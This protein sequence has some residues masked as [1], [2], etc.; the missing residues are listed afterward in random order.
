MLQAISI[1]HEEINNAHFKAPEESA[2]VQDD[3][4]SPEEALPEEMV[5]DQ[6][7]PAV[8]PVKP[9]EPSMNQTE[10]VN[11]EEKPARISSV[12]IEAI[13]KPKTVGNEKP[14]ALKAAPVP[15]PPSPPEYENPPVITRTLYVKGHN[16]PAKDVCPN[17]GDGLKLMILITT[18]PSHSAQ[19]EAVRSTWGHVA[20]RRDVGMAFFVGT[21][22][23]QQDNQ[24]IAQENLVYGDIIQV[25][26]LLPLRYLITM[27]S[28]RFL[29]WREV[30][31]WSTS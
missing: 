21:S 13:K 2:S 30:R 6:E 27:S 25:S 7:P 12:D 16:L 11:K 8:Q 15:A 1:G 18:A 17:K 26:L 28:Y 29:L 3:V 20:F 23:N 31:L 10:A 9:E 19:R 4:L 14:T 22:K 24:I 5:P